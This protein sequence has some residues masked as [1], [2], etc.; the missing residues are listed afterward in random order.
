MMMSLSKALAKLR[1]GDVMYRY[2]RDDRKYFIHPVHKMLYVTTPYDLE[3]YT[4]LRIFED[5]LKE[6]DWI[7]EE[8]E[9]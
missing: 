8:R 2:A 9:K 1:V 3:S 4:P 7:I 5:D 6:A